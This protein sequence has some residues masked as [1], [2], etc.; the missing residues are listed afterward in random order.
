MCVLSQIGL[1]IS[2]VNRKTRMHLQ[3]G[4]RCNLSDSISKLSPL[5]R[6]IQFRESL[7]VTSYRTMGGLL[8]L[9][10]LL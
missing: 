4:Q 10:M 5:A 3:A 6:D 2:K 9:C 1:N 7:L 8:L